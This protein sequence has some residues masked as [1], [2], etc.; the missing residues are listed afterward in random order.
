[1]VTTDTDEELITL[2]AYEKETVAGRERKVKFTLGEKP[3]VLFDAESPLTMVQGRVL[4]FRLNEGSSVD[5]LSD[6][7]VV[8][9]F[10]TQSYRVDAWKGDQPLETTESL[11]YLR[12]R[13][14]GK[15]KL[16]LVDQTWGTKVFDVI[17]Q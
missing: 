7:A 6:E 2:D 12:S 5:L 1:M 10:W 14:K 9:T 17:V 16:K 8:E 15:G 11:V 4:R 3:P 13:T